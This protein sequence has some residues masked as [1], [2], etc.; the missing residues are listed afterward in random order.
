MQT[1]KRYINHFSPVINNL[2]H[3]LVCSAHLRVTGEE[4]AWLQDYLKKLDPATNVGLSSDSIAYYS[5]GDV[6]RM[7]GI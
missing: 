2:M 7:R 3:R 1:Y 5:V 4:L 6:C